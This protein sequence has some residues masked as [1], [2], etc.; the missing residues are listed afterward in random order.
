MAPPEI[1]S[2]EMSITPIK[3]MPDNKQTAILDSPASIETTKAPTDAETMTDASEAMPIAAS[4]SSCI[5]TTA[6]IAI[7][8]ASIVASIIAAPT[9][10]LTNIFP[11]SLAC[12]IATSKTKNRQK[13]Y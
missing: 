4:G 7:I 9:R 11:L 2:P 12:G 3:R 6:L 8:D 13:T 5:P 1:I 10:D